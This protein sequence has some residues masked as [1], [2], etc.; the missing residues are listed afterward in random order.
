MLSLVAPSGPELIVVSGGVMSDAGAVVTVNARVAGVTSVLPAASVAR[1]DTEW[2]P[3]LRAVVVHGVV[4]STH[5]PASTRHSKAD[6][7]SLE[8]NANVG[9]RL[10]VVP[11][12]PELIVVSGAVVS[13]AGPEATVIGFIV[14]SASPSASVTVTRT[15]LTPSAWKVN[16]IVLP[17]PA[18]TACPRDR[19][20]RRRP[21]CTCTACRR[22]SRSSVE[23]HGL[24]DGRRRR[25]VGERASG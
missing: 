23:R 7:S 1:T 25:A 9:V 2:G 12:G 17:S 5:A 14:L 18:A 16:V 3:S 20:D 21:T 4:Q 13:A 10:L 19:R 15:Y 24:A 11:V 6:A 8:L 22:T